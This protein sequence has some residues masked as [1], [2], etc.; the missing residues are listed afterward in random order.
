[1]ALSHWAK[2]VPARAVDPRRNR[3]AD[4]QVRAFLN[5][6]RL[7]SPTWLREVFSESR[8]AQDVESAPPMCRPIVTSLDVGLLA[9]ETDMELWI[10][11]EGVAGFDVPT[12]R[13]IGPW[14]SH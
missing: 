7:Q 9:T 1:V 2:F 4:N 10:P 5:F 11:S 13:C 12:L 8:T 3:E 14:S 6:S